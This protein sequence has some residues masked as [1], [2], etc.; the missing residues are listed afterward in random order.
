M[1]VE[2]SS[3]ERKYNWQT[4][5]C[6]LPATNMLNATYLL[7]APPPKHSRACKYDDSVRGKGPEIEWRYSPA[8]LPR[9]GGPRRPSKRRPFAY[10]Y[11]LTRWKLSYQKHGRGDEA[12]TSHQPAGASPLPAMDTAS[13]ASTAAEEQTRSPS[14]CTLPPR[15]ESCDS[16]SSSRSPILRRAGTTRQKESANTGLG[17]R[18]VLGQRHV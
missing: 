15:S 2:V 6:S 18:Q 7:R 3:T 16:T 13:R 12:A 9:P 4:Q 11:G 1:W 17:Q 10:A 14:L 8:P 5:P